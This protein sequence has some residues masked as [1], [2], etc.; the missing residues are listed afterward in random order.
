MNANVRP[1]YKL[2]ENS[3]KPAVPARPAS[4]SASQSVE[5]AAQLTAEIQQVKHEL[6]G[7]TTAVNELN[8]FVAELIKLLPTEM[9]HEARKNYAASRK[10]LDTAR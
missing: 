1:R 7:I 2:D 9:L 3:P 4:P 8:A 10:G 5:V 6:Q